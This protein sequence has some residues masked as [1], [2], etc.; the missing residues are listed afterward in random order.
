VTRRGAGDTLQALKAHQK[1]SPL[2]EPGQADLTVW[3]DFPAVLA[4]AVEAGAATGPILT[5]GAF[6][7]GAGDR[8]PRRGLGRHAT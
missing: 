5:Q 1:V 8:G 4:A 7:Q 3:A 6:L 2:A